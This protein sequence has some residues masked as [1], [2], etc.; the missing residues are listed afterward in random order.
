VPENHVTLAACAC[1]QAC[2]LLTVKDVASILKVHPRTV[3]R[4]SATGD[5]PAPLA[6][7]PKTIRWRLR[8][9]EAHVSRLAAQADQVRP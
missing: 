6:L 8:D 3:W 5:I 2:Q 7:A 9:L 4:M 1:G